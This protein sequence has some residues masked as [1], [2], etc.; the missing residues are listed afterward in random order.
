MVRG[1]LGGGI[2]LGGIIIILFSLGSIMLTILR[3]TGTK[4]S[5]INNLINNNNNNNNNN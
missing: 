3:E 1:I 4:T 5:M 2:I